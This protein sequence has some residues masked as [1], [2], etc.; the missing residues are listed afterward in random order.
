MLK[1]VFKTIIEP[2]LLGRGWSEEGAGDDEKGGDGDAE[3]EWRVGCEDGEYSLGS[4][5][6]FSDEG[7]D[8]GWENETKA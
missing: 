1:R 7:E 6:G 4:G 3:D 5:E 2:T 8:S